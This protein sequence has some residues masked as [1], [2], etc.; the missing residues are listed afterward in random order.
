ML[1]YRNNCLGRQRGIHCVLKILKGAK[2]SGQ[3]KLAL[4]SNETPFVINSVLKQLNLDKNIFDVIINNRDYINQKPNPEAFLLAAK[5]LR[6]APSRIRAYG[7]SWYDIKAM[8]NAGMN[9][10]DVKWLDGYPNQIAKEILSL[11]T[12]F[13]SEKNQ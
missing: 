11:K 9:V 2:E 5:K 3:L 1:W 6:V 13:L 7:D 10:V 12:L 4:V 8:N